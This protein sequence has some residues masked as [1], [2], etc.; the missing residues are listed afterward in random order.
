MTQRNN[1]SKKDVFLSYLVYRGI[2]DENDFLHRVDEFGQDWNN[3]QESLRR[4]IVNF[5]SLDGENDK[6]DNIC[7]TGRQIHKDYKSF[8]HDQLIFIFENFF[9][10]F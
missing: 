3:K 10:Y 5:S 2:K 8:T 4:K 6:W 7:K 1:W 9:K